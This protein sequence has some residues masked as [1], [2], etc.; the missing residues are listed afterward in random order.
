MVQWCGRWYGCE[1][2]VM[3]AVRRAV[4]ILVERS[5]LPAPIPCGHQRLGARRVPHDS[6]LSSLVRAGVQAFSISW[7]RGPVWAGVAVGACGPSQQGITRARLDGC[8]SSDISKYPPWRPSRP[9]IRA[10]G[11]QKAFV[12]DRRSEGRGCCGHRRPKQ[13]ND[14]NQAISLI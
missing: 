2:R 11:D 12:I 10:T 14:G 9:A 13:G 3:T 5:G 6:R 1:Q 4:E 7:S 8:H